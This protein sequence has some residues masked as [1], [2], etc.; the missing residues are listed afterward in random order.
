MQLPD[1]GLPLH[2][3]N[4][5]CSKGFG[6]KLCLLSPLLAVALVDIVLLSTGAPLT[7]RLGACCLGCLGFAPSLCS[8][9]TTSLRTSWAVDALFLCG[10]DPCHLLGENLDTS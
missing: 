5:L 6:F 2:L 9:G 8:T 1:G 3:I 4:F 7:G 10:L